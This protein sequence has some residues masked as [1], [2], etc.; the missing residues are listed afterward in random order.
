MPDHVEGR[1]STGSILS[2]HSMRMAFLG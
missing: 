1:I 2:H